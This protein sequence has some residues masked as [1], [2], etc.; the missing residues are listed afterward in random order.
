MY[1]ASS[2]GKDAMW[3]YINHSYHFF[4]LRW[5]LIPQF[6]LSVLTS[7]MGFD[8]QKYEYSSANS[9]CSNVTSMQA[10]LSIYDVLVATKYSK[11]NLLGILRSASKTQCSGS[12]LFWNNPCKHCLPILLIPNFNQFYFPTGRSLCSSPHLYHQHLTSW[13]DHT[14]HWGLGAETVLLLQPKRI[15]GAIV[16]AGGMGV[17]DNAAV[18]HQWKA[19]EKVTNSGS[20]RSSRHW[21][22][23]F[24]LDNKVLC[25]NIFIQTIRDMSLQ[26]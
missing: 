22:K 17:W 6:F 3:C 10:E 20:D 15:T 9:A 8:L 14:A 18:N 26:C 21:D 11:A 5:S 2:P 24:T 23:H 12:Q 4:D 19:Y 13:K 1:I 25:T 16:T 7:G